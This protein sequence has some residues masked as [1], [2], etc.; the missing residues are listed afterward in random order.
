MWV[1]TG[2]VAVVN[3]GFALGLILGV[4]IGVATGNFGMGLAL[5]VAMGFVFAAAA[6]QR[7]P[8]SED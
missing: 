7:K 4:A 6:V 5:G 2:D 1:D 8:K 3:G